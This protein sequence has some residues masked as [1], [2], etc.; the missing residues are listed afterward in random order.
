[1]AERPSDGPTVALQPAI[2]PLGRAEMF[3]DV[4]GNR[5]FFGKDEFH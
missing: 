2:G 5:V 4:T 3:V 1:M